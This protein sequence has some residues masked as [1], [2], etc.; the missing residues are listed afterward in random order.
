MIHPG[1][2]SEL[3]ILYPNTL[4]SDIYHSYP[5][6]EVTRYWTKILI[7]NGI[8]LEKSS[9]IFPWSVDILHMHSRLRSIKIDCYKICFNLEC[10]DVIIDDGQECEVTITKKDGV[11]IRHT[12]TIGYILSKKE[13]DFTENLFKGKWVQYL[14][15]QGSRIIVQFWL[16]DYYPIFRKEKILKIKNNIVSL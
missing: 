8:R 12:G 3:D 14:D 11:S 6:G 7:D 5:I 10:S 4:Y 15:I 2:S 9:R 1:D 13:R 16:E